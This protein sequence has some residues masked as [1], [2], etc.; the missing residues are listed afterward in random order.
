[1]KSII[2][3][4][5]LCLSIA[6]CTI[7]VPYFENLKPEYVCGGYN[8]YCQPTSSTLWAKIENGVDY[9]GNPNHFLG[10]SYTNFFQTEKCV[11]ETIKDNNLDVNGVNII[12]GT[13]KKEEEKS[14]L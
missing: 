12:K 3:I 2:A 6:G 14:R 10:R 1:M 13:L 9:N 11:T 7:N 8:E 5:I 4:I